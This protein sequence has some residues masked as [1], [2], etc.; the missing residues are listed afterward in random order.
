M[1]KVEQA[2]THEEYTLREHKCFYK[3]AIKVITKA[4]N[5]AITVSAAKKD[6]HIALIGGGGGGGGD[7][8]GPGGG[9][10]A[11]WRKHLL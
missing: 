5:R 6:L 9:D 7:Q 2:C 8:S 11:R 4:V 3:E 1:R 10:T